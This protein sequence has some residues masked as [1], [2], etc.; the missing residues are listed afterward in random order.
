MAFQGK[1]PFIVKFIYMIK[2]FQQVICFKYLG[3]CVIYEN[4]MYTAENFN[5][6][7]GAITQVFKP[8]FVQ[9]HTR[10]RVYKILAT[11]IL[12]Y[13]SDAWTIFKREEGRITAAEMKFMGRKA[14]YSRINCKR[15][16]DTLKDLNTEPVINFIHSCRANWKRH[17]FGYA[18]Q[19]FLFKC[20][21]INQKEKY[22]QEDLL[23]GGMRE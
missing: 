1:I 17:V 13:G 21:V 22:P 11:S 6:A 3:Y 18:V 14:G 5:R 9:K 10:I 7:V 4:E 19:E 20:Y 23:S 12:T 8:N 2:L 15:I 16:A